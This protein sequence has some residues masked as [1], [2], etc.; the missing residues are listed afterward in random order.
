MT[1]SL[2]PMLIFLP[3][4]A[5]GVGFLLLLAKHSSKSGPNEDWRGAFL[6]AVI[7]WGAGVA[8]LSEGLGLF[9]A[10]RLPWIALG[11][12]AVLITLAVLGVRRGILSIGWRTLAS[13]RV[14]EGR[15]DRGLLGGLAA[16]LLALLVVAWIS[17]PNNVDSLLYH[18]SR[19]MHWIQNGSLRHYAASYHH[20][21]FMPPWA[22]MAILNL[23]VLWGS[24]KP[25]NLI[26]WF[27]MIG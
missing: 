20:Q 23:R 27:S 14:P 9:G 16:L 24:D 7:A 12:F 5:F 18:M 19:V 15:W 3:L 11:W 21:L 6:K 10:L 4:A 8:V 2:R 1:Q 22:E 25:V 17:P 13:V 26:Q